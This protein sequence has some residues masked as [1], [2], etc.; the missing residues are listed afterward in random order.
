MDQ[1]PLSQE[2]TYY[3]A[4]GTPKIEAG[5]VKFLIRMLS[6][7]AGS[8]FILVLSVS[9][10]SNLTVAYTCMSLVMPIVH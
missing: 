4:C 3:S 5:R 8:S 9:Y 7:T 2:K 6:S 1:R 10:S